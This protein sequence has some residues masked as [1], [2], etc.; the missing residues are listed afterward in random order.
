MCKR[1]RRQSVRKMEPTTATLV[2]LRGVAMMLTFNDGAMLLTTIT[3]VA[4]VLLEVPSL[5]S[6]RSEIIFQQAVSWRSTMKGVR[7]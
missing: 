7:V 3:R 4:V 5:T 1:F 6:F 2:T